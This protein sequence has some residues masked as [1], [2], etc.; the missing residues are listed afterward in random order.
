MLVRRGWALRRRARDKR[1]EKRKHDNYTGD[2]H[3]RESVTT[4]PWA[5]SPGYPLTGA[6]RGDTQP[7]WFGPPFPVTVISVDVDEP[8]HPRSLPA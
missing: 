1:H 8:A 2:D 6:L 4:S 7:Y 5:D 3:R